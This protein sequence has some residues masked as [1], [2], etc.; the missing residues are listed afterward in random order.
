MA[1][2]TQ[3]EAGLFISNQVF[4]EIEGFGNVIIGRAGEP[5]TDSMREEWNGEWWRIHRSAQHGY[6]AR[7]HCC[8]PGEVES[9]SRQGMST[10][11]GSSHSVQIRHTA[12][13]QS[14]ASVVSGSIGQWQWGQIMRGGMAN[15]LNT[16][17]IYSYQEGA[18]F[19]CSSIAASKGLLGSKLM[20]IR[21][22]G[23]TSTFLTCRRGVL[24]F[25][26]PQM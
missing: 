1:F 8:S 21:I 13:A 4:I 2:C 6:V 18:R 10:T 22:I 5:G 14:A 9:A 7:N 19:G 15:S 25:A 20:G 12:S 17:I 11:M 3:E 26:L 24:N 16:V 23:W